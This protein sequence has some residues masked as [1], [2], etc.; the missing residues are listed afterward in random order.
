MP[1]TW[2]NGMMEYWK[3]GLKFETDA[4]IEQKRTFCKGLL[5]KKG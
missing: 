4:E 3:D 5:G 2:K 1:S